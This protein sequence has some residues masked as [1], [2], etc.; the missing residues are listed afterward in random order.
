MMQQLKR[1]SL[2]FIISIRLGVLEIGR[3]L[4]K[5]N[6]EREVTLEFGE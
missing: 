1:K 2:G 5:R 3:V 6:G 4:A